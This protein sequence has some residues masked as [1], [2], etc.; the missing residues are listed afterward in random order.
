M[1][2]SCNTVHI[3]NNPAESHEW[4]TIDELV[5]DREEHL[6]RLLT[7][8]Q[9]SYFPFFFFFVILANSYGKVSSTKG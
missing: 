7:T 8:S 3:L 4:L 1:F 5:V 9:M 6:D 2:Y